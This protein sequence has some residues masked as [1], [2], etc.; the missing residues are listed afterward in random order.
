M[1]NQTLLKIFEEFPWLIE[2]FSTFTRGEIND[3]W[4][5]VTF[6][7]VQDDD[8]GVTFLNP[9]VLSDNSYKELKF[10]SDNVQCMTKNRKKSFT[11]HVDRDYGEIS[12]KEGVVYDDNIY[13]YENVRVID[14][15]L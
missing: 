5:A 1:N 6:S 9:N 10:I 14:F 2:T 11:C 13:L 3:S 12:L 8:I 7:P 15:K 4:K